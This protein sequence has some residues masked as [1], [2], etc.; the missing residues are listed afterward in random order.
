MKNCNKN[1]QNICSAKDINIYL[2]QILD[3]KYSL[4]YVLYKEKIKA[5]YFSIFQSCN[6]NSACSFLGVA[7]FLSNFGC[8]S[9]KLVNQNL[10]TPLLN[11]KYS[12]ETKIYNGAQ[13]KQDI[14]IEFA[15]LLS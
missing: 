12:G 4:F 3:K 7:P 15:L 13:N 14:S 2:H 1:N 11:W 8:L 5:L 6:Q 10:L 9:P